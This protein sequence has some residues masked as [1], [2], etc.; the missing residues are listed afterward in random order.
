MTH[1][2]FTKDKMQGMRTLFVIQIFSTLSFSVLY[3]TLVLFTTRGL[4][5]GADTAIAI[6]GSF[7]AFNYFLHL[8]GGYIGGR[9]LSYRLLFSISML[10][11][12]AGCI[13]LAMV[14]LE[15]LYWGLAIFLTG[16]G[17]NVTCVNC[18]LT[19]LF[20]SHDKNRETAFLW[21]YSGMNIGFLIGFTM[22]GIFQIYENYSIL[23]L[24]AGVSNVV[25]LLLTLSNWKYLKDVGTHLTHTTANK[26][27]RLGVMGILMLIALSLA[28][29]WLINHSGFSNEFIIIVGAIMFLIIAGIAFQQRVKDA[30][31]KIWAY[32]IL[33]LASLVFWTLYQMAP[34]GLTLFILHNVDRTVMGFTVPPQWLLNINTIIII[35]AGPTLAYLC[36]KL[37]ERGYTI[38]IPIQ[39][40]MALILI[41]I[42]FALLPLGIHFADSKGISG[43]SWVIVSYILQ[44]LGEILL[45]PIGYAMIGQLIP[46]KL[47]GLMMGTWLMVVGVSATLSNYFSQLGF[48]RTKLSNPL[49]TNPSFSETFNFL[50]WS[51]IIAGLVLFLLAP[52]LK[53]L[54]QEKLTHTDPHPYN[55][56]EDTPK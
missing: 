39:F 23:F 45:S 29:R 1:L 40:A 27:F 16:C 50:G 54:I 49:E 12:T 47:Q 19:Q 17:L 43:F 44:S 7:V 15:S 3:S 21:N 20:E 32:F 10:F 38:R 25:T 9:F 28:L 8:L 56:P 22:S 48:D 30:G 33:C 37:R 4:H 18:M 41:G 11:Q 13:I 14:N 55:A 42:G 31:K 53:R 24:V 34:M 51:A 46:C 35:V 2:P 52:F 5:L 26:Q 36:K 6:T